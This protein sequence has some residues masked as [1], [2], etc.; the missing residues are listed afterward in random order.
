MARII[1]VMH[2]HHAPAP[3]YSLIT[4]R[5]AIDAQDDALLAALTGRQLLVDR[6]RAVKTAEGHLVYR[7]G[8]EAKILRRLFAAADARIDR[9]LINQMWRE[10]FSSAIMLQ[11]PLTVAV[12]EIP[13]SLL[14]EIARQSFGHA[15]TLLGDTFDHI[16][17]KLILRE[18]HVAVVPATPEAICEILAAITADD[19]IHII[20]LLPFLSNGEPPRAYAIGRVCPEESGDD[21]TLVRDGNE[22]K[23]MDGFHLDAPGWLGIVPRPWKI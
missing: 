12:A 16:M 13:D 14:R 8:R 21:I 15:V 3:N 10:I 2:T 4:L 20:G 7:P 1:A 11:E 17:Q 6:I 22:I 9:R 19:S 23:W 5:T 18:V